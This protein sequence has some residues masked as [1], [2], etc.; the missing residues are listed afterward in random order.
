M[1]Y[2]R[3]E[4]K[5]QKIASVKNN[6]IR[7]RI[8][9][10]AI[11][12]M[13]FLTLT[14][15]LSV[16]GMITTDI[17]SVSDITYGTKISVYAES[18]FGDVDFEYR[19]VN[20]RSLDWSEEEPILPG[21]Y[22][23]RASSKRTIGTSY[24]EP[25]EFTIL[26]IESN[27]KVKES[28]IVFGDS[29]NFV[30]DLIDG[31][32]FV[33]G[34]VLYEDYYTLSSQIVSP[35]IETVVIYNKDGVDVTTAYDFT[36]LEST[37]NLVKRNV[38]FKLL[39]ATKEY[40]GTELTS[41][42]YTVDNLLNGHSYTFNVNGSIVNY[43]STTNYITD[44]IID[45]DG[46]DISH[47]YNISS[48]NAKLSITKKDLYVTTS[49]ASKTYDST[50]LVSE[51]FTY[52]GLIDIDTIDLVNSTSLTYFGIT[53]NILTVT[54]YNN[55]YN[56]IYTYGE[57]EI[58]KKDI[59]VTTNSSTSTYSGLDYY[60]NEFINSDDLQG[61]DILSMYTNTKIK[62]VGKE[63]NNLVIKAYFN[64]KDISDSYNIIYTYGELEIFKKDV[65]II[66]A[67][68]T[69]VYDGTELYNTS[70]IANGIA[71]TDKTEVTTYTSII[72]VST[73][74]NVIVVSVFNGTTNV[75]YCYN[76]SYKRNEL[77][78]TKRSVVVK[79]LDVDKEYDGDNL[80]NEEWSYISGEFVSGDVLSITT[81]DFIVDVEKVSY[82]YSSFVILNGSK[83]V[84]DNYE[85]TINS[86]ILE[87]TAREITVTTSS[88]TDVYSDTKVSIDTFTIT[89]GNLVKDHVLD[90]LLEVYLIEVGTDVNVASGFS[91]ASGI[92]DKTSNYEVTFIYGEI[93]VTHREITIKTED[94]T[95]EYDDEIHTN[96][97]Y[98]VES[99]Y[100][101][102]LGHTV[103]V[104]Y[105]DGIRYVIDSGIENDI[106]SFIINNEF[107]DVTSNY[108]I[109][110]ECGVYTLT[111]R[112]VSITT[113]SDE[114]IYNDEALYNHGFTYNIGSKELISNH[115][116]QIN[117]TGT[118][119][120]VGTSDNE[121]STYSINRDGFDVTDNYDVVINLGKLVVT[122]RNIVVTTA[123]ADFI[124]NG[125]TQHNDNYEIDDLISTHTT[126]ITNIIGEKNVIENGL[127]KYSIII[128]KG[129][130]DVTYNYEIKYAYGNLKITQREVALVTDSA[131]KTYDGTELTLNTFT[132]L[133]GEFVSFHNFSID[134]TGTIT[135]VESIDQ[136]GSVENTYS[137]YIILDENNNDVT[138]NYSIQVELGTLEIYHVQL[139]IT[140]TSDN[141]VF[142]DIDYIYHGYTLNNDSIDAVV[143]NEELHVYSKTYIRYV[144]QGNLDNIYDY[145]IVL[146]SN[147]DDVT[148]NY[149]IDI[150]YGIIYLTAREVSI[151]TNSDSKVYDDEELIAHGFDYKDTLF[152]IVSGH[153]LT[154]NYT[155][156]QTEAGTSFNS[157]DGY[158]IFRDDY[159]LEG[160]YIFTIYEGELE[161]TKREITI[162]SGSTSIV[163]NGQFLSNDN[164][165]FNEDYIEI[166]GHDINV[167]LENSIIN[168][169][170]VINEI[171][172]VYIKKG[173][174]D[175]SDNYEISYE[176]GYLEITKRSITIKTSDD[177]KT[178]DGYELSNIELDI[179]EFDEELNS[180]FID[181]VDTIE[182]SFYTKVIYFNEEGY[183]N[184]IEVSIYND[185]DGYDNY[186]IN[187]E[188]GKL[189]IFKKVISITTEDK[190]ET[191]FGSYIECDE[192]TN[193]ELAIT[194]EIF[195]V[196]TTKLRL[197]S[198][199]IIE[200]VLTFKITHIDEDE[201]LSYNYD[202]SYDNGELE[203]YQFDLTIVSAS[204]SKIY[205][206][207]DLTANYFVTESN[208]TVQ[209]L[210]ADE[211][212]YYTWTK[213]RY[214]SE[215]G[216]ENE[217]TYSILNIDKYDVTCNYNITE[218]EKGLLII[219]RLDIIIATGTKEFV[220]NGQENKYE[221]YALLLGEFFAFDFVE[222]EFTESVK[223]VSQGLVSNLYVLNFGNALAQD[224]YY[225]LTE[226]IG[227]I[228][229]SQTKLILY[230]EGDTKEYD[231]YPL[232]NDKEIP[233]LGLIEGD[234]IV[235][236]IDGSQTVV[237]KSYNTINEGAI[238]INGVLWTES[239]GNYSIEF[240]YGE[241]I[242][243]SNI[244][245]IY[246]KDETFEYTGSDIYYGGITVSKGDDILLDDN[247]E[248]EY[249]IIL[250]ENATLFISFDTA[251]SGEI[252]IENNIY[253]FYVL[254]KEGFEVT[255]NFE[256]NDNYGVIEVIRRVIY[257]QSESMQWE[258]DGQEHSHKEA[259]IV[260]GYS[261]V[262]GHVID[263]KLFAV[264]DYF[265][266]CDNTFVAY[267]TYNGQSMDDYYNIIYTGGYGQLTII[268][269]KIIIVTESQTWDYNGNYN[270][271][272]GYDVECDFDIKSEFEFVV[273]QSSITK[274]RSAGVVQNMFTVS[275]YSNG[276][277]IDFDIEYK[278]GFLTV[279]AIDVDYYVE[280]D[281]VSYEYDSIAQTIKSS[282]V[283][284]S[285]NIFDLFTIENATYLSTVDSS[286]LY[287]E[288]DFGIYSSNYNLTPRIDN[289][290]IEIV[291]REL[292]LSTSDYTTEFNGEIQYSNRY[293]IDSGSFATGH[294]KLFNIGSTVYGKEINFI[295]GLWYECD[296]SEYLIY[297]E[298]Y[299]IDGLGDMHDYYDIT[300]NSVGYLKITRIS[301]EI[302]TFSDEK[303]YDGTELTASGYYETGTLLYGHNIHIVITGSITDFGKVENGYSELYIYD[304]NGIYSLEEL[305]IIYDLNIELG[306]L[307]ILKKNVEFVPYSITKQYESS[308]SYLIT[309]ENY[310]RYI[311]RNAQVA[312]H[313]ITLDGVEYFANGSGV[314][315]LTNIKIWDEFNN[316]VTNNYN[317]STSSKDVTYTTIDV[318]L[319]S[320][321]ATKV[322]DSSALFDFGGSITTG[323]LLEGHTFELIIEATRTTVGVTENKILG[324]IIYDENGNELSDEDIEKYYNITTV[325]GL[326]TVL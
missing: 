168:V 270:Y 141:D 13:L 73:V 12:C 185:Y 3:Y 92:I 167:Q 102:V 251:H 163:Y 304:T 151:I 324:Y 82:I 143:I 69:K 309:T 112:S 266:S 164:W 302:E 308:S 147:E 89:E 127:N 26:P 177:N 64:G 221:E 154:I 228:S 158:T 44:I 134:I 258:Y 241:L 40:D 215:G 283:K 291:K 122:V 90:V 62:F 202:I 49:S 137:T 317:I 303:E 21:V 155:G 188:Y 264:I 78:V 326:L 312:G 153:T 70:H 259:S 96:E 138:S 145:F 59:T 272:I 8:P 274:I 33:S 197:Y 105:N 325:N 118:Q 217:I 23:V 113:N 287:F 218:D 305:E 25:V 156:T 2:E 182:V 236:N 300:I 160:N 284:F 191:Y 170:K 20:S 110:F 290:V 294:E 7:F 265:G 50:E 144:T 176:E 60:D 234:T 117:Y 37:I 115:E 15:L 41:A 216:V 310:T 129:L 74:D 181:Y 135:Y 321:S 254:N 194:D 222:V 293:S 93:N 17:E 318:V 322:H 299:Y 100:D 276:N 247:N 319:T 180:G 55:N 268:P 77:E 207:S 172:G 47:M 132:V 61:S 183:E 111:K 316:D 67:Q 53:N 224:S 99:L 72:D 85:L 200:N 97:G 165:W 116:F 242:V 313:S 179:E 257:V 95:N 103:E 249:Q 71:S 262:E 108:N 210:G 243:T 206:G 297:F 225:I 235:Y 11:A 107:G 29:F 65:T 84:K 237:G 278:Y 38:S 39:D 201:D 238:Y 148:Y 178:Y 126:E 76:I 203:M 157:Y 81:E 36:S 80:T 260:D 213:I 68:G 273:N 75:D 130:K 288:V 35:I 1:L 311:T 34:D 244:I 174:L 19:L 263:F 269:S 255:S 187:Y 198:E 214:Y 306:T 166:S 219:E 119:T 199:G 295:D 173:E 46:K 142:A 223:D 32:Y 150:E 120:D 56:I 256:I 139:S 292:V 296:S 261:L 298:N 43:G 190:R 275:I 320:N 307:T 271:H 192:F 195:V 286:N 193:T 186:D 208:D 301:L 131:S 52:D 28:S 230:T 27:L 94:Y 123:A 196:D 212:F 220:Y 146:N 16:K 239:I 159:D 86:G 162:Y 125:E 240:V 114:I 88:I 226:V 140:T 45:V 152:E 121:Y 18:L 48:S 277:L 175:V 204:N 253:T 136:I 211:F 66:S 104:I 252:G 280:N 245:D 58:T 10:I 57:L 133:S 289:A 189:K 30:A 4:Q 63:E 106:S 281:Y 246:G 79:L 205:D 51:N 315:S 91:I 9:L 101:I 184:I 282:D 161:V 250:N 267:I 87:I 169:D 279:N 83:D 54:T 227:H 314:F 128:L 229:V 233:P 42:D 98:T 231:G 6:V 31:D 323:Y 109:T 248:L 209:L 285:S 149:N 22:E 5:M 24:G 14:V 124:Y 171:Y 232:T